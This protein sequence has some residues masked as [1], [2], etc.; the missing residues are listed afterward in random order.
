MKRLLV[1]LTIGMAVAVV[2][3]EVR[4]ARPPREHRREAAI[5]GLVT[6]PF[7]KTASGERTHLYR[8][9]GQGGCVLDFTDYGARLVRAYVP[10]ANGALVDIVAGAPT[11]VLGYEKAGDISAVWK[12][13]PIRR[14][15]AT[16]LVFEW[17][18][19]TKGTATETKETKET[20]GTKETEATNAVISASFISRKPTKSPLGRVIYWLD[21]E[22][23]FSVE[24][25]IADTNAVKFVSDIRLMPLVARPMT[26]KTP[27]ATRAFTTTTNI[28]TIATRPLTNATQKTEFHF[29]GIKKL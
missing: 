3:A 7:G 25:T 20:K 18:E 5:P 15:R 16:G 21:A 4:R 19:A 11:S 26:V 12:M 24:S 29:T 14:P 2:A 1:W 23:N 27:D 10:N 22:N 28:T 9:M 8:I 17:G 6:I 13:T